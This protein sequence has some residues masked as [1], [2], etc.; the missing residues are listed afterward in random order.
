MLST[1]QFD[2]ATLCREA[3]YFKVHNGGF[4]ISGRHKHLKKDK[5]ATVASEA[6]EA[7]SAFVRKV[8]SLRDD[9]RSLESDLQTHASL[10]K[11]TPFC[12]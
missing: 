8:V 12:L 1:L 7:I 3:W 10:C 9:Y 5:V 4:E 6:T 11:F 2:L